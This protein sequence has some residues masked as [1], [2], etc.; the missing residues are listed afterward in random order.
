MS[1]ST[2]CAKICPL[3]LVVSKQT[4]CVEEKCAWYQTHVVSPGEVELHLDC[5]ENVCAIPST[6]SALWTIVNQLDMLMGQ[7]DNINRILSSVYNSANTD[8]TS[9]R[10]IFFYRS[11]GSRRQQALFNLI[12]FN[13]F[14][15]R[16]TATRIFKVGWSAT[17]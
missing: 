10:P 9:L 16:I 6:S 1:K 11:D 12:F 17:T 13:H 4:K 7:I 3:T 8:K 2:S 5:P 14:C 15:L